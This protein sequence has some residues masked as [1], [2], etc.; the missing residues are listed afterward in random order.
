[1]KPTRTGTLRQRVTLQQLPAAETFDSFG[2][3]VQT[4]QTVGTY[5]AE[6]R[7]LAGQE[8][9]VARQV[10]AEATHAVTLRYLGSS[11]TINPTDRLICKGRTFGIVEIRN[12]EER[13]RRY[14]LTVKE[15]QTRSTQV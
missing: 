5:W 2:Q 15:I 3:P 12:V 1:M 14:E 10:K 9:Y 4:Y 8:A 11:L 7:P 13:N 6:V